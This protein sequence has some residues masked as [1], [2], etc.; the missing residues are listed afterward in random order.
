MSFIN[1]LAE[2]IEDNTA[3]ILDTDLL[4]GASVVGSPDRCVIITES[5]G[6]SESESG[7]KTHPVQIITKDLSYFDARARAQI[8]YALL[9]NKPGFSTLSGV[10]YCDVMTM[11]FFIDRSERGGFIFTSNLVFQRVGS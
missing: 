5:A 3:L 10:F 1:D 7:M 8:T 2:Y 4:V 11:P 6:G 9:A